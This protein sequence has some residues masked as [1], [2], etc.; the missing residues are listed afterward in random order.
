MPHEPRYETTPP[1]A[2]PHPI[3]YQGSKRH[4]A[5]AILSYF[6]RRFSRLV[7]PLAGSA[8]IS[9]AAAHEQRA[10]AFWINDAHAPLMALW[11]EII[12][13]PEELAAN[14]S[15][16]WNEQ[17][18]RERAYYDRV[19]SA[20]NKTHSPECLLYLLARC[21]KAAVRYNAEGEFN[22]SPDNRRKGARPQVMRARLLGA[23]AL[24]RGRTEVTSRDCAD[25]LAGC[26]SEDLI[27]LDPP[28]QGV[29]GTKDSRYAPRVAPDALC[30]AL[31]DLNRRGMMYL[32]SYDGRTGATSHGRRLP[33]S[34]ELLHVE[35]PAGRSAQATLLGR[36][37]DTYES[38][39]L[40]GALVAALPCDV[41]EHLASGAASARWCGS[42]A[43]PL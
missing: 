31:A 14:Y 21:V 11:R 9:L 43:R 19:R 7:E 38:L 1:R 23:S 5:A 12:D 34:L 25:V 16:L 24:L 8:A 33:A 20:F 32:L 40:S 18:G 41:R 3:P 42:G 35:V 27:Y 10:G 13:R 30:A 4:L 37:D 39:Y 22:N 26:S 36:T 6:P 17:L 2:V 28:Y 15:R 29:C